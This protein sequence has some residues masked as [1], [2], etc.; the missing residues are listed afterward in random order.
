MRFPG[1]EQLAVLSNAEFEVLASLHFAMTE[2]RHE[3]GSSRAVLD[4]L[5]ALP[6]HAEH[7]DGGARFTFRSRVL[8]EV[9]RASCRYTDA[10]EKV[11][12]PCVSAYTVLGIAVSERVVDGKVPLS[13]QVVAELA[14]E[15]TLAQLHAA[16]SVP[17]PALLVARDAQ[18]VESA[19][20]RREQLLA[21]VEG[22]YES[23]ADP[24]LPSPLTR[25]Q[26]A[27]SQLTEVQPEGSDALWEGLLEAL[28]MLAG[29]TP[30][31]VAF[32]LRQRG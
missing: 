25:E 29:Q 12:W 9:R 13:D 27:V 7:L 3:W 26:A 31:D 4:R 20:G 18:S 24:M 15:P 28:V 10:V 6:D 16:L 11:M 30:S 32:H 14:D 19:R 21:R 22:V 2:V 8:D 5:F 23:L 17:V 1:R